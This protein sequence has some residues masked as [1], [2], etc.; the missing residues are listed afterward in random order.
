MSWVFK[1]SAQRAAVAI[2]QQI[3]CGMVGTFQ[4]FEQSGFGMLNDGKHLHTA[5][6]AL[7]RVHARNTRILH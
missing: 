7:E 3:S 6:R 1:H 5:I 4:A 2:L